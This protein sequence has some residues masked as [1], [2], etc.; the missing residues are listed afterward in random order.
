MTC[1][2]DQLLRIEQAEVLSRELV[3][4]RLSGE[5]D[6]SSEEQLSLLAAQ[7]GGY[8]IVCLDVEDVPFAGTAFLHF[9]TAPTTV[10]DHA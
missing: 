8:Q 6:M 1:T 2:V 5:I 9:L 4:V 10:V 3:C 7:L